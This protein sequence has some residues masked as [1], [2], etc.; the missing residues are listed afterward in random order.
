MNPFATRPIRAM[1]AVA[2][3]AA[4][5]LGTTQAAQAADPYTP[6]G[7][8]EIDLVAEGEVVVTD[9]DAEAT[10]EC[11]ALPIAG[12]LED[13]GVPRPHSEHAGTLDDFSGDLCSHD[14]FGLTAI[15][16][17]GAWDLVVTGDPVGPVWPVEVRGVSASVAWVGC[18]YKLVGPGPGGTISGHFNTATQQFTSTGADLQVQGVRGSCFIIGIADGNRVTIEGTWTNVAAAPLELSH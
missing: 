8:P 3:A 11:T 7:G 16:F 5:L 15:D 10:S 14:Y 6:S 12:A 1:L 4:T 9:L 17:G 2:L 13:A 18:N